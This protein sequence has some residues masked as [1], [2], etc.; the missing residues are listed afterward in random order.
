MSSYDR[1]IRAEATLASYWLLDRASGP[2][3]DIVAGFDGTLTGNVVRGRPP[4]LAATESVC[5]SGFDGSGDYFVSGDVYDF[6]GTAPFT[7]LAWVKPSG[8][9]TSNRGIVSK[10]NATATEGW[11]LRHS[12]TG[13]PQIVRYSGGAAV[14]SSAPAAMVVGE[15]Y[16]LAVTYDGA[17][18]RLYVFSEGA[19]AGSDSDA[20]PAAIND[21]A[22]E[23]RIGSN[24]DSATGFIGDISNVAIFTSALL[25]ATL[26]AL[27]DMGRTEHHFGRPV[28]A[29]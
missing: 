11:I 25:Q 7:V 1:L 17:T 21:H 2:E 19:L 24:S 14:G 22:G 13:I 29:R 23:F 6:A 9:L 20:A 15:T 4:L 10:R 3:P 5:S 12:S 18:Q 8:G 27:Y 28:Y 16:M 26:Q